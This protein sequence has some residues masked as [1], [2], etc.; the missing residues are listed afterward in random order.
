MCGV[1]YGM[2]EVRRGYKEFAET[3]LKYKIFGL[4]YS[5][6]TSS[7]GWRVNDYYTD[8]HP[9]YYS[10]PTSVESTICV[11]GKCWWFIYWAT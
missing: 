9:T 11:W 6:M 8:T 7:D 2:V 1:L 5:T 10:T 3:S 4:D